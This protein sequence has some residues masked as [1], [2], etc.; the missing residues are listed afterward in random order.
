[1]SGGGIFETPQGQIDLDML[2][3]AIACGLDLQQSPDGYCITP[4]QA[5]LGCVARAL[6]VAGETEV[7]YV[8]CRATLGGAG[9]YCY[10]AVAALGVGNTLW[11]A[12]GRTSRQEMETQCR[13]EAPKRWIQNKEGQIHWSTQPV[14]VTKFN[15][16]GWSEDLALVVKN[17]VDYELHYGQA[18]RQSE[19]IDSTTP[20]VGASTL[21]ARL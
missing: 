13:R 2:L 3:R 14:S 10:W 17:C 11:G 1:M 18:L 19:Q 8:Q 6:Q 9:G 7:D 16:V 21:R 15:M 4:G 20:S 12:M 5:A